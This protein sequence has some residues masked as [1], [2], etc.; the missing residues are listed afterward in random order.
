LNT[1]RSTSKFDVKIMGRAAKPKP[2]GGEFDSAGAL[3]R[4]MSEL[5]SSIRS[6]EVLV[7]ARHRKKYRVLQKKMKRQQS[8]KHYE[9]D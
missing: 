9:I 8:Q 3:T 4:Q 6:N 2:A 7:P 1:S 5:G